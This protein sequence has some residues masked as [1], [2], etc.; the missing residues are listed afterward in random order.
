MSTLC[1]CMFWEWKIS[2]DNDGVISLMTSNFWAIKLLQCNESRSCCRC[3]CRGSPTIS[4]SDPWVVMTSGCLIKT[5]VWLIILQISCYLALYYIISY[6]I[7]GRR[8]V[9]YKFDQLTK[10]RVV[11]IWFMAFGGNFL[12]SAFEKSQWYLLIFWNFGNKPVGKFR[13]F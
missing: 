5:V 13:Q 10:F 6:T 7:C 4:L 12:K 11:K 1:S 2:F 3:C 8:P 9:N